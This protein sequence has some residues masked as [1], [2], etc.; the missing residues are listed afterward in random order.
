[1][2]ILRF[3]YPLKNPR[4][5]NMHLRQQELIELEMV[6]TELKDSLLVLKN[7]LK[8]SNKSIKGDKNINEVIMASKYIEKFLQKMSDN[9]PGDTKE[10]TIDLI[11]ER[12]V[13]P[14]WESWAEKLR[15][16]VFFNSHSENPKNKK[17][18]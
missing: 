16:Q 6:S 17:V 11:R 13:L 10:E 7:R 12:S 2:N 9:H 5:K 4:L 1:M 15:G 8:N 14:E 18:A 3:F